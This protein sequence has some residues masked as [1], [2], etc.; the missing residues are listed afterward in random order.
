MN[1]QIFKPLILI[2]LIALGIVTGF[3][4]R[5]GGYIGIF[6]AGLANWGSRQIFLDLVIGLFLFWYV[7]WRDTLKKGPFPWLFFVI[8]LVLGSFGPLLY[9]LTR[10]VESDA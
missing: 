9:F 10:S 7:V 5:E 4:F 6:E 8:T 1:A 3:A 2:M